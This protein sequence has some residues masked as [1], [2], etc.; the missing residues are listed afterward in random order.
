[1]AQIMNSIS[2]LSDVNLCSGST[3]QLKKK[4]FLNRFNR[5]LPLSLKLEM[6]KHGF[7]AELMTW[8]SLGGP[9][10]AFS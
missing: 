3:R 7:E 2:T 6:L 9:D 4:L 5:S 8:A 10:L 1:M